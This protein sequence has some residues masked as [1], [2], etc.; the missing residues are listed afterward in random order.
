MQLSANCKGIF[1]LCYTV[2]SYDAID[3]MIQ[4][5]KFTNNPA[6]HTKI[7][8]IPACLR[9]LNPALYFS[10]FPAAVTIWKPP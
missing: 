5:T 8:P 4:N 2:Y 7:R 9:I 6:T 10:S 3:P 1:V